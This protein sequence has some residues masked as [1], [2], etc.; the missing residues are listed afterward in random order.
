ME[1]G[2]HVVKPFR[3]LI[4]GCGGMSH[5]WVEYALKQRDAEIVGLVDLFP[6][7]AT[8]LA[9]QYGLPDMPTR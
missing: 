1:G 7:T 6:E 4:A 5:T 8:R 9:T 3:I 2:L